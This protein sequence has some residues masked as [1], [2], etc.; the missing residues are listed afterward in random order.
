ME[1]YGYLRLYAFTSSYANVYGNNEGI[2]FKSNSYLHIDDVILSYKIKTFAHVYAS[3]NP[4]TYKISLGYSL[5][6][7]IDH[8]NFTEKIS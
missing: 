2:Y 8:N 1:K 4:K 6:N 7:E 3:I 5:D